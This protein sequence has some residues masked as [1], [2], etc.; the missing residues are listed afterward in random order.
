MFAKRE[1]YGFPA[2]KIL[3]DRDGCDLRIGVFC[4]KFVPP[5]G[6]KFYEEIKTMPVK[7][8]DVYLCGYPKTGIFQLLFQNKS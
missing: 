6:D 4:D 2:S 1:A 8:D 5:F 3:Q 7:E